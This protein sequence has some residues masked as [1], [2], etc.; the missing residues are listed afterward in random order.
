M[1]CI[2]K[3]IVFSV[4]YLKNHFKRK[5]PF[6]GIMCHGLPSH[7]YQHNPAKIEKLILDGWILVYPNYQGTWASK[8]DVSWEGCVE[9]IIDVAEFISKGNL[10]SI[11]NQKLSFRNPRL[12]LIGGSFGGS[13]ALVAG[14]KSS[15]VK[16]IVCV[17]GV[18]NWRNH[19]QIPEEYAEPF[20]ELYKTV[21]EGF[22]PLWRIPSKKEWLRLEKGLVDLNPIDYHKKLSK[23]SIFLVYG[24][25]DNIVSSKRGIELYKE[26]KKGSGNHELILLDRGHCDYN[27]F[28]EDSLYKKLSLWLKKG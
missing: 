28:S 25:K 10:K 18:T 7:P 5:K 6:V 19:Q 4:W 22:G 20:D 16:N 9:T 12:V 26:L 2:N 13:V 21:L 27:V 3:N 23:K 17:A 15:L 8:G 1:K 24:K 11:K 14:A